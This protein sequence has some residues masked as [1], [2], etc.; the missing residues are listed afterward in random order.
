MNKEIIKAMN[1]K[2]KSK[3]CVWWEKNHYKVFRVIL[4][5]LWAISC[6]KDKINMWLNS[7]QKWDEKRATE[8]LNYYIP[9]KAEWDDEDKCFYFYDNGEGWK[10]VYA[11]R[12]LKRKDRRFWKVN[13]GWWGG[14]MRTFLINKFEL[15]GFTKEVGYCG[16]YETEITYYLNKEKD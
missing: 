1:K 6:L 5:P 10:L 4:F 16:D 3:L 7:K 11:K 15:D 12:Y 14:E 9:R 8:I 13:C 2:S